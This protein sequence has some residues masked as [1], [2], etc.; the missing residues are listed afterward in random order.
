MDTSG[1]DFFIESNTAKESTNWV[2]CG[3]SREEMFNIPA[4]F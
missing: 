3:Q 1:F 2:K 4:H